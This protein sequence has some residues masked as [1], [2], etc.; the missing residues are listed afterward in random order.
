MLLALAFGAI[1]ATILGALTGYA[2]IRDKAAHVAES[3][4][5][6]LALAEGGL[7]RYAWTLAH[8]PDTLYTGDEGISIE[9]TPSV[10]CGTTTS[11]LARATGTP[12]DGNGEH[13]TVS[14]RFIRP[15]VT[16]HGALVNTNTLPTGFFLPDFASL[17][18][19]AETQGKYLQTD[20]TTNAGIH[21]VFNVDGTVM[22]NAVQASGSTIESES[23]LAVVTLPADCGLIFIDS[24][25]WIEG[26]M[27][28]K[29]TVVADTEDGAANAFLSGAVEYAGQ[30]AGLTVMTRNKVL[31]SDQ[32]PAGDFPPFTPTLGTDFAYTDWQQE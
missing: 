21:L 15:P 26:T 2:V 5:E 23:P 18:S 16:T 24:N 32:G 19:I 4:V 7:A 11:V 17:K 25:V 6:A 10:Q 8:T 1:F 9:T 29:V 13:T 20:S 30:D 28:G 3:R 14:A 12:L 22:A 31:I 27:T